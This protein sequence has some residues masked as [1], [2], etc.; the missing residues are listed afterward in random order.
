MEMKL[1]VDWG[2]W[3]KIGIFRKR[4]KI[5]SILGFFFRKCLEKSGE[6]LL[7]NPEKLGKFQRNSCENLENLLQVEKKN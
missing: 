6:L 3:G 1:S 5:W 4:K 2:K 7:K